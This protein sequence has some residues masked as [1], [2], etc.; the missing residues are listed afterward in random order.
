MA[1]NNSI[2]ESLSDEQ[3]I[4]LLQ[5]LFTNMNNL[6]KLYYDMFINTTPLTL[7]LERYNED[8]VLETY[9]LPNRAKDRSNI[10]Q[11]RG[12]PERSQIAG[13]G[14]IYLDI[15]TSNIWIKTNDEGATGWVML[16]TPT[17]FIKGR[18]YLS[19]TGDAS[20]LK[21]LSASNLEGG[22]MD[23]RVGGTGTQGLVGII[24]GRGQELPYTTAEA[25]IDYMIPDTFIG[26]LGLF[27]TATLP[28][29]WIPCLGQPIRKTDYP[30]LYYA[31]K[32][33]EATAI[34]TFPNDRLEAHGAGV[35]YIDEYGNEV[36]FEYDSQMRAYGVDVAI[37]P[38]YQDRYIRGW[39]P[40]N[41]TILGMFQPC[42]APNIVGEFFN[43]QERETS[44]EKDP[45]GAF[46]RVASAGNGVDGTHG[47]FER[48]RFSANYYTPTLN[49]VAQPSVYK[50]DVYEIRVN[51]VN[52]QIAIFAGL[53][54]TV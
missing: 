10:V 50:D 8:G 36:V 46:R 4:A 38:N 20:G 49:G 29:G 25:G 28:D 40:S 16:Y 18:E 43:S 44:L 19:P 3:I 24:K 48:I 53:P 52:A 37:V 42:A 22:I 11:G 34:K 17:N 12:E 41:G 6:D 21:G 54:E 23:V 32:P 30:K 15:L 1:S 2:S 47:W 9:S 51:N 35:S 33:S 31:L 26:A 14:T 7:N 5:M 39:N 13:I 45:T 27:M